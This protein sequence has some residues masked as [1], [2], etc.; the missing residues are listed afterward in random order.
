MNR[1]LSLSVDTS[2]QVFCRVVSRTSTRGAL[3]TV[4]ALLKELS[5]PLLLLWGDQVGGISLLYNV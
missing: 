4:N 1:V 5:V 3:K 2:N